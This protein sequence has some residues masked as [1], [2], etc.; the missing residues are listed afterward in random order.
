M[1]LNDNDL[2]HYS[3][4]NELTRPIEKKGLICYLLPERLEKYFSFT[5][6]HLELEYNINPRQITQNLIKKLGLDYGF[7]K[8]DIPTDKYMVFSC[9]QFY[10]LVFLLKGLKW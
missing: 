7:Y 4:P 2:Q 6:D 10:H 3:N 9:G 5:L 8:Y 1:I